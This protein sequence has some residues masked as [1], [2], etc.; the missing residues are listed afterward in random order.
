MPSS[1]EIGVAA[2]L[3]A[4]TDTVI[5]TVPGGKGWNI[6]RVNIC[7]TDTSP[8]TVTLAINTGGA[9]TDTDTEEKELSI[10]AKS[11]FSWGPIIVPAGKV[12][13]AKADVTAKV[14]AH[15]HGWEVTP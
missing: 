10:P 12:L 11:S 4:T 13:Q 7:N 5:G 1:V 2:V 3:I 6:S 8:R 15:I 9:I 14:N